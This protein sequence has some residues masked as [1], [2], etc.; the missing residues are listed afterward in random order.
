MG[1]RLRTLDL[2]RSR[3]RQ[4]NANEAAAHGLELVRPMLDR[5]LIEFGLAVPDSVQRVD[6]RYRA[7]ARAALADILPP[8]F[9]TRPHGQE[10][11]LPGGE[12]MI[13][14]AASA[15]REDLIRWQ[16]R[17]EL[18]SHLRID[19]LVADLAPERIEE[20]DGVQLAVIARMYLTAR[21]IAWFRRLN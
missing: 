6:G 11:L 17:P 7:L 9:E 16:D 18:R 10:M 4:N 3:A 2:L 1:A 20:T 15:M 13:R 21:Y 12:R 5:R 14:C 19:R 8:E